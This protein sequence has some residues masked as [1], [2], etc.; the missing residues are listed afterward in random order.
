MFFKMENNVENNNMNLSDDEK[1][2]KCDKL[3][4][5]L[6]E[7]DIYPTNMNLFKYFENNVEFVENEFKKRGTT[8]FLMVLRIMVSNTMNIIKYFIE[9]KLYVDLTFKNLNGE[10][11]FF[12]LFEY[13]SYMN[14]TFLFGN[15]NNNNINNTSI[16]KDFINTNMDKIDFKH[17][18]KSGENLVMKIASLKNKNIFLNYIIKPILDKEIEKEKYDFLPILDKE[19]EKEKYDF[20]QQNKEGNNILHL[21]LINSNNFLYNSNLLLI[22]DFFQNNYPELF[23]QKNKNNDTPIMIP[24]KLNNFMRY[25]L[26]KYI[27]INCLNIKNNDGDNL[28]SLFLKITKKGVP[29][30][31]NQLL[32]L[33]MKHSRQEYERIYIRDK[34]KKN[35]NILKPYLNVIDNKNNTLLILAIKLKDEFLS[36]LIFENMKEDREYIEKINSENENAFLLACKYKMEKLALLMIKDNFANNNIIDKNNMTSLMYSIKNIYS[37]KFRT[38]YENLISLDNINNLGI[39]NRKLNVRYNPEK[40]ISNLNAKKNYLETT[41]L[42]MTIPLNDPYLSVQLIFYME[43][44]VMRKNL[45]MVKEQYYRENKQLCDFLIDVYDQKMNETYK[46]LNNCGL[47][48]N[49]IEKMHEYVFEI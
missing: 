13:L 5:A 37:N 40:N 41:D 49:M 33:N 18:N 14:Q 1:C 39:I 45:K 24:F 26:I 36:I 28:L 11:I 27:N 19:I 22:L 48:K 46:K 23:L 15:N 17:V 10:D 3:Y 21:Y 42:C 25:Q 35:F 34:I 6:C 47:I 43:I 44:P 4:E 16:L 31:L 12:K 7:M 29:S 38:V 30:L 32:S 8:P 2:E 9:K 20:L